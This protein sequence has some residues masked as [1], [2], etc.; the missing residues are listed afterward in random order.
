MRVI[1]VMSGTSYDAID[2]AA[3]DLQLRDDA[4][5]MHPLGARSASYADDVRSRIAAG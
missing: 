3:A 2:V 5:V 4:V 1:G